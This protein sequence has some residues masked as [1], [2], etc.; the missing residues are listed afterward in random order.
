MARMLHD[1]REHQWC[2]QAECRTCFGASFRGRTVMFPLLVWLHQIKMLR[3][4]RHSLTVSV[5]KYNPDFIKNYIVLLTALQ[6]LQFWTTKRLCFL[7]LEWQFKQAAATRIA[8]HSLCSLISLTALGI[9]SS[10]TR[11]RRLYLRTKLKREV[12]APTVFMYPFLA[13]KL[14]TLW[15]SP[16]FR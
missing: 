16:G 3:G 5:K 12:L 7:W 2:E 9:H 14:A 11:W 13:H 6:H 4:S 10:E 15:S 8:F 1:Q